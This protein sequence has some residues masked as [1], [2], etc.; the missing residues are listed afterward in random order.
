ML[1]DRPVATH[2][3]MY[4]TAPYTKNDVDQSISSVEVEKPC[5]VGHKRTEGDS[6]S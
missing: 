4:R 6:S 1:E 5:G 2:A 3:A